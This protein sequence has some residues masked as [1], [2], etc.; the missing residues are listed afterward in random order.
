MRFEPLL[1]ILA[2]FSAC[3]LM[4]FEPIPCENTN[5]CHNIFSLT[6]LCEDD[7]FCH[8]ADV[9]LACQL[10]VY[11]EDFYENPREYLD[12]IPIGMLFSSRMSPT[13]FASVRTAFWGNPEIQG[14]GFSLIPCSIDPGMGSMDEIH[15]S[16]DFLTKVVGVPAIIGGFESGTTLIAY[17]YLR[18]EG[19]DTLLFSP[20]SISPQIGSI[21]SEESSDLE[22][23]QL[24]RLIPDADLF[25]DAMAGYL[26]DEIERVFDAENP[27]RVLVIHETSKDGNALNES[28]KDLE[29]G[30]YTMIYESFN[31]SLSGSARSI[32]LENALVRAADRTDVDWLVFLS[33]QAPDYSNL[34]NLTDSVG[35]MDEAEYYMNAR[36]LFP[37]TAHTGTLEREIGVLNVDPE[38]ERHLGTTE[39]GIPNVVGIS[40][41]VD[42]SLDNQIYVSFEA[43]FSASQESYAADES[44]FAAHTYDAT[45]LIM[46]A[47]AW[48]YYE[49]D[50][51]FTSLNGLM[52][53]RGLRHL[54]TGDRFFN[55]G[56]NDWNR[57]NNAFSR[58]ES[59]NLEGA[60]GSLDFV[61]ETE[62]IIISETGYPL[63][64]WGLVGYGEPGCSREESRVQR[65]CI[66][67]LE[68][69]SILSQ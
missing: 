57:A 36:F 4:T 69:F 64:L 23:G 67:P 43:A 56:G 44:I 55:I 42:I 2:S 28:F 66:V 35:N 9:P 33:A 34:M 30:N 26:L 6:S 47:A 62:E 5:D 13:E 8:E 46:Y 58:N 37:L 3:S 29:S 40:P 52:L 12:S 63:M 65:N 11:P 31:G 60:S 54:Q 32:E 38:R 17:N 53:R 7:G 20:S 51:D 22:P 27:A 24:W 14:R 21:E 1:L 19:L 50:R 25:G 18:S 49:N 68:Y 61:S 48:A 10:S 45:W 15:A 59:V 41:Y 39:D 16:I